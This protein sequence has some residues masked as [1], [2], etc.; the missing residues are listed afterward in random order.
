MPPSGVIRVVRGLALALSRD[1][2][3]FDRQFILGDEPETA[4]RMPG[5]SKNGRY[6]YPY[7]HILADN[8]FV[9]YSINKEDLAVAR[10]H[11][12]DIAP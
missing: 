4:P 11:L 8:V 12:A 2:V 6:G 5:L 10:F 9:I 7:L 3:V 1:G